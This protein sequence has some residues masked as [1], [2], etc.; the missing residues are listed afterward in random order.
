MSTKSRILLIICQFDWGSST[1]NVTLASDL[2][3]I[4]AY[5]VEGKDQILASCSDYWV[6]LY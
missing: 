1:K 6:R 5:I 3:S 4:G 2:L